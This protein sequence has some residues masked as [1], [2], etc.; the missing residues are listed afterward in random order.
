MAND[1][2][3]PEDV[4]S[5]F[6]HK[7]W[8]ILGTKWRFGPTIKEPEKQAEYDKAKLRQEAIRGIQ[9]NRAGILHVAERL[10]W[11]AMR[12]DGDISHALDMV[13][14]PNIPVELK[15]SLFATTGDVYDQ[16]LRHLTGP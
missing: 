7:K 12:L 9:E 5:P 8:R 11:V 13:D 10:E 4:P 14:T 16:Y 15:D 1:E 3:M 6:Y 2:D